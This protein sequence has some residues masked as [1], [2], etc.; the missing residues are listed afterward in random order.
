MKW[1]FMDLPKDYELHVGFYDRFIEIGFENSQV[2]LG[3]LP[4]DRLTWYELGHLV[5]VINRYQY[6]DHSTPLI[7]ISKRLRV[8]VDN[9]NV[10]FH[11]AN[12]HAGR[13]AILRIPIK[14][15]VVGIFRGLH[16]SI[17]GFTHFMFDYK[18]REFNWRPIID[19][20]HLPKV[21]AK[22]EDKYMIKLLGKSEAL[23]NQ[24][25]DDIL[26]LKPKN[27]RLIG[28]YK[29]QPKNKFVIGNTIESLF[30]HND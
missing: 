30:E 12:F 9:T 24:T 11:I 28:F 16:Y 5:K 3:F 18:G 13:G 27:H 4:W 7:R 8:R 10:I 15:E 25:Y 17:A 6:L 14:S 23:T 2:E 29:V 21:F 22:L 19:T 26:K 1:K 20:M